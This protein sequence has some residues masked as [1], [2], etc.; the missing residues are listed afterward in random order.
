MGF[1]WF[2]KSS[3]VVSWAA[4]NPTSDVCVLTGI[5]RSHAVVGDMIADAIGAKRCKNMFDCSGCR[6]VIYFDNLHWQTRSVVTFLRPERTILY[7]V[8][9]GPSNVR[10]TTPFDRVIGK[11]KA[12]VAPSKFSAEFLNDALK[13]VNRQVDIIIPHGIRIPDKVRPINE[14]KGMLYRTY[15]M[16]RKFPGYGIE[17]VLKFH[18][19]H[20]D[21][22]IDI[23]VPGGPMDIIYV[24]KAIPF[25]KVTGDLPYE[26][27]EELY[28][29]HRFWLNLSDNEGFGIMPIEAMAHGEVVIAAGIP[30]IAETVPSDSN[31]IIPVD[32]TWEE[33]W[34]YLNIRHYKYRAEDM[35]E[36]M[37]R[38]INTPE[39]VLEEY[40]RR[41]VEW[42][43]QFDYK[44]VYSRFLELI[45]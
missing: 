28:D 40:S 27:V 33:P 42:A 24:V 41:N 29:T 31:F 23:L 21:Y 34:G 35:V 20:P 14:K 7:M 6:Y 11:V 38:A 17:A 2:P 26:K 12:I 15:Y 5:P 32:G 16:K 1:A 22:P 9:E 10:L 36:A 44:K 18:E 4:P 19:L 13:P 25:S 37:E 43:K 3:K 30:T 45:K 39:A 8:A